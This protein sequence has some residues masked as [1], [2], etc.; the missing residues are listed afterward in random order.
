[1]EFPANV[2]PNCGASLQRSGGRV[3][4]VT[5]AIVM[6]IVF[7]VYG[8]LNHRFSDRRNVSPNTLQP[9]PEAPLTRWDPAAPGLPME[10]E[11]SAVAPPPVNAGELTLRDVAAAQLGAYPVAV[12]SSGWFAF[13]R[14]FLVGAYDWQVMLTVGGSLA[15]EGGILQDGDPVGLW[16]VSTNSPM[17]GI[18][19]APWQRS[20]PLRWFPIDDAQ[21]LRTLQISS[22]ESFGNFDRIPF[23]TDI[24]GPG[25]FI[26]NGTIVGWSFGPWLPGG[27]L[28]TGRRGSE[29]LP[30]FYTEDFYRL[31]FEGGREEALLLAVSDQKLSDLQLL[32]ALADAYRL[33]V[34]VPPDQLPDRIAPA[35]IHETMR[36]LVADL[37]RQGRAEEVIALFDPQILASIDS[38][39]LAGDLVS[40]AQE[41]GE[42]DYALNVLETLGQENLE[43]TEPGGNVEIMQAATY[44]DWLDRLIAEGNLETAIDIYREASALLPQD[45]TIYLAGVELALQQGD[46]TLA[47]R[48]LAA[49]GYPPDLRDR[50]SRLEREIAGLKSQE[51]KI[52][53]RFRPGSLTVPVT[54]TVGSRIDQRFLVD[55]GASVVT[56]PSET[57]HRLKIDLSGS[58]PRR[59][60]YSA[61]GVQNAVEVTLPSIELNGWVIENV[62]ALVV[63]LP[64]QP[65]VGLL[66]MTYLNHFRI[67]LNTDEGLLMLA[68]R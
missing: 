54:A 14:Q 43:K 53:I 47:E 12:V 65:G 61:T 30:E 1:M 68:P 7:G 59:L 5:A 16:Q 31:T 19:L 62:K 17:E 4:V 27:Y 29:L 64:G 37:C 46:W 41:A 22:V 58:L 40:A 39:L 36:Q 9:T 20:Q 32:K 57:A 28:W 50:V 11:P 60:F 49:R 67:D 25:V 2:C 23:D 55:T 15:V 51:G 10:L 56:V 44:R 66:G 3:L 21:T 18:D 45:A 33:E 48:L 13:P 42:Y 6:A 38:P 52:L 35:R 34:R 26:Q 63:D 8:Y 24:V